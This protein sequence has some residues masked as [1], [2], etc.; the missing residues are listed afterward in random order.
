MATERLLISMDVIGGVQRILGIPPDEIVGW[1]RGNLQKMQAVYLYVR[2]N[3]LVPQREVVRLA[4]LD[5][6][7]GVDY[8]HGITEEEV[9]YAVEIGTHIALSMLRADIVPCMVIEV[10]VPSG[11]PR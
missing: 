7:E 10:E 3:P 9:Q 2:R 4:Q 8:L 1:M 5:P 6:P 11:N